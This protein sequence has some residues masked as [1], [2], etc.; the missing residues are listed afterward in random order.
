MIDWFI[1]AYVPAIS[2]N[3]DRITEGTKE[4]KCFCGRTTTVLSEWTIPK[5][6]DVGLLQ[7]YCIWKKYI[8]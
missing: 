6:E 5:T 3:A 8:V 4:Q 2:D 1:A 7:L